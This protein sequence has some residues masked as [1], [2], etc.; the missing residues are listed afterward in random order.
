M[1]WRISPLQKNVDLISNRF[2]NIVFGAVDFP[3]GAALL[4][5][6]DKVQR[7]KGQY[8]ERCS[9]SVPTE[10][11]RS[12]ASWDGESQGDGCQRHPHAL[13]PNSSSLPCNPFPLPAHPHRPRAVWGRVRCL[14][15][16]KGKPLQ[17][18]V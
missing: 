7:R 1:A 16:T 9:A 6:I 17:L 2:W 15:E 12:T 5:L 13:T 14:M 18:A 3:P 10:M 8:M 4:W 11:T